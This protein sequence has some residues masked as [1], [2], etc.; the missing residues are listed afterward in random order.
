VLSLVIVQG[1]RRRLCLRMLSARTVS[2]AIFHDSRH[3]LEEYSVISFDLGEA[4]LH[5]LLLFVV[6]KLFYL[7]DARIL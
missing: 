3:P 4:R 7:C 1:L 2:S 5:H 6:S